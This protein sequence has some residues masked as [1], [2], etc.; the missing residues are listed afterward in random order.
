MGQER[1]K[2]IVLKL[3]KSEYG[4]WPTPAQQILLIQVANINGDRAPVYIRDNVQTVVSK[5][6]AIVGVSTTKGP[7]QFEDVVWTSWF[8]NRMSFVSKDDKLSRCKRLEKK[9]QR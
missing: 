8:E 5:V 6:K 1:K 2:N 4:E 3:F 9:L 7:P